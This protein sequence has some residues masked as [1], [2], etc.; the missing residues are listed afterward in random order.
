MVKIINKSAI[1]TQETVM[2]EISVFKCKIPSINI[3]AS[4]TQYLT[5][6]MIHPLNTMKSWAVCP[7]RASIKTK[8]SKADKDNMR[9]LVIM[10]I[11]QRI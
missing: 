2:R 8:L 9:A 11:T 3:R 5:T 7:M 10:M 1:N 4:K 6:K